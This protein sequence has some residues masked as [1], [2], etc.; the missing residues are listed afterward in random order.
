[1]KYDMKYADKTNMQIYQ[2]QNFV[3]IK[4]VEKTESLNQVSTE[5]CM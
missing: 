3:D 1:M 5:P 4:E 2:K